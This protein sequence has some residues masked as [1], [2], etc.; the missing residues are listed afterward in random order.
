[1]RKSSLHQQFLEFESNNE[2]F[3]KIYKNDN[4]WHLIRFNLFTMLSQEINRTGFAHTRL[5]LVTRAFAKVSQMPNFFFKNPLL[6]N[7]NIDLLVFNHQRRIKNDGYYECLFTDKLL[8]S[9]PLAH[10]TIEEPYLEKH[11]KP[12]KNHHIVYSDWLNLDYSVVYLFQKVIVRKSIPQEIVDIYSNFKNEFESSITINQ[13]FGLIFKSVIIHK[14]LKHL[15]RKVL[16]KTRPKV[17]LEVVSYSSSRYAINEVAKEMGIPTVELQHGVIGPNHIAYNFL[18]DINLK[19]FPDYLYVFG[20]Y[21]KKNTRFPINKDFIKV[22]GWPYFEQKVIDYSVRI[23][24]DNLTILFVS[25]GTIGNKLSKLAVE[26]SEIL[27]KKFKVV[28]KLHPGEYNRWKNEYPWL[29]GSNIEV[30][31]HNE[32]DIHYYLSISKT[33]IGV[34]STTLFESLGYGHKIYVVPLK[35]YERFND[36]ISDKIFEIVRDVKDLENK[37]IGFELVQGLNKSETGYFW[38]VDSINNIKTELLTLIHQ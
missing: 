19:T 14:R 24:V 28:Y 32:R 4:Y 9:L 29:I 15:Y 20:E 35:G 12:I 7:K 16:K 3:T 17:I 36:L 30:I 22:T 25:Q 11:Y 23:S 31:D 37:I 21:W 34:D 33:I 38:K 2:L 6:I 27:P 26:L 18:G 10:L 8:E 1:M 13:F 5:R